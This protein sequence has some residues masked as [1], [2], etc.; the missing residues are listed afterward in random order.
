LKPQQLAVVIAVLTAFS[1]VAAIL[2]PAKFGLDI[3]G[4]ARVVLQADTSQLPKG[5]AWDTDTRNAVLRTIERRVNSNGVSEPVITPKGADQFV[6]EIPSIRNTNEVIEELQN[7]AQLQF[8]YSPDWKSNANRLGRYSFDVESGAAGQREE[9]RIADTTTAKSFRDRYHLNAVLRGMIAD[10]DKAG[11]VASEVAI[12]APLGELSAAA[13]KPALR[14]TADDAKQLPQLAEELSQFK[15]FLANAQ[16]ELDGNDLRPPTP[17]TSGFGSDGMN[18]A[19]VSL[20]FNDAG[21]DKFANFTRDHTNEILM[22]YLDGQ[23][24]M[25]PNITEPILDGKAQISPFSTLQDAK[26][27]ADYINSGALPVPLKI[28]Q[29]Q[30]IEATLGQGAVRQGFTAGLIGL[31]LIVLFMILYYMLPGAVACLAL[32]LYTLFTYAV[33]VLIPVTFTLP[34]IAGFILSVGMAVDANILIFERTKEELRAGRP[35]RSAIEHGFQRA[36]SAIFDS[37]VCTAVTSILLYYFGTGPVRGFALTLLIGV[38]ISMFTAITVTRSFLLLLVRN[39]AAQN[40]QAWGINRQWRPRL[41]VVK[42]RAWWYGLSLLVIVPTIVFAALGGFKPGIDFTGGTELTLQFSQPASAVAVERAVAAAGYPDSAAQIA[43]GNTVFVRMPLA[44]GRGD[45]TATQA[46]DLVAKL[47]Q[48]FPGV[49][50]QGFERIGSSI[51]TELT[52]NAVLS[53]LLSSLFIVFYL[54]FRFAIGGFA[55]GLKYGVAAVV[56]MLHDVLVLI[57]VF[58]ALGYFLNWKIDSLFVTAALTVIGFSVHDTIVIFDR[59]RENLRERR[60]DEDFDSLVDHSIRETFARSINT[61]ATVV[62]TLLALLIFGGPVIRPLNAALLI[63]IISGTYSSIFNAAPLVV[64]WARRMGG[65]SNRAI[66]RAV[67]APSPRPAT[68]VPTV[69]SRGED[70]PATPLSRNGDGMAESD[71]DK[72]TLPSGPRARRRRM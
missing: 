40:L 49:T 23:I 27:L 29:Q 61:S 71:T 35:L 28:V 62:M 56:A 7:T 17:A 54:A 24:L 39:K 70:G 69:A 2:R 57:G 22:I 51:S 66:G 8:F 32:L 6:V 38:A 1:F 36:F 9:Y 63:G 18:R 67:P 16:L 53:V 19:V 45:I 68:V 5:Q 14:L 55:N 64:D 48:T 4:G 15:S 47:G 10:A 12:P 59:I 50:Q 33:F 30:T 41:N 20:E 3:N 65:S 34:G 44:A 52:R 26:R 72:S 31:G 46:N 42:S 25:A 58:C 60:N 13:G 21:R 11:A 43:G 37:N